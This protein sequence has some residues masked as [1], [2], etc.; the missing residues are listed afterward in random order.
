[1]RCGFSQNKARASLSPSAHIKEKSKHFTAKNI[2]SEGF[3]KDKGMRQ[4]QESPSP[5]DTA[6]AQH[7]A[8]ES[9]STSQSSRERQHSTEQQRATA[10]HRAADDSHTHSNRPQH[11]HDEGAEPYLQQQ[12]QQQRQQQRQRQQQQLSR[13]HADQHGPEPAHRQ[14]A[15]TAWDRQRRWSWRAPAP[16][17]I[18]RPHLSQ[19]PDGAKQAFQGV[20]S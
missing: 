6:A 4:L 2:T 3:K 14:R 16:E 20:K 8:A 17:V 15:E 11:Y 18:P 5:A 12:Q 9:D 19:R 13:R 1:M 10:Q 7:R